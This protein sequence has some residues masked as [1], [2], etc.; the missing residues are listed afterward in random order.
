MSLLN[1]LVTL[2]PP[3]P[4]V[5]AQVTEITDW[6]K[7]TGKEKDKDGHIKAKLLDIG[8][9]G[10][11]VEPRRFTSAKDACSQFATLF[12]PAVKKAM[13]KWDIN[14]P[15]TGPL[16]CSLPVPD[17]PGSCVGVTATKLTLG[18]FD[19]ML[20]ITGDLTIS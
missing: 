15:V 3:N 9:E 18:T 14:I 8:I 19:D 2:S 7:G 5:T 11:V 13:L 4:K 1:I 10:I 16:H 17:K 6:Q 20:L 12:A